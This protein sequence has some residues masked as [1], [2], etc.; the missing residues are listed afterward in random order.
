MLQ[1]RLGRLSRLA[2]FV[3]VLLSAGA[4]QASYY[5][6]IPS[7]TTPLEVVTYDARY[8]YWTQ[9][10]YI[11]TYPHHA[12]SREGWTSEYYG[13]VQLNSAAKSTFLLWSTW[14]V[15][16]KGAPAS[17]IDFVHAGPRLGWHRSTWE[18]S[19]GGVSGSWPPDEFKTGQ[20]YRFVHRVWR[21]TDGT[22]HLGYAGVWMKA[23]ET[24]RWYHMATFKF[25][26]ELTGFNNMFGF[27][28]WFGPD[29]PRKAAAEFRN[30][31]SLT[32]GQWTSRTA[33]S[34]RN[35]GD[36]T[37][38]IAP[39][40]D[41]LGVLMETT[42]NDIDPAT[43]RRRTGP[44]E[45]K[46]LDIRQ[47]EQ[48]QILDQPKVGTPSARVLGRQVVCR[49]SV[50]DM[51]SPQLGYDLAIYDGQQRVAAVSVNDPEAR[52]AVVELPAVPTGPVSARLRLRDIFNQS[53]AEVPILAGPVP[54][55]AATPATG[56]VAGLD[57]AYY[58]APAG[59]SWTRLPA[60]D[61][62]KPV[63]RGVTATPDITPRL[64]RNGYA[65]SYDG[66]LTVPADGIYTF[67]L[68]AA[69]GARLALDG[70]T[71][72]DADGNRS[73]ARYDGT[74]A[75]AKGAHRLAL[76][77]Y[78][79]DGRRNQ[80][81]DFLQLSWA[82]P[83]FGVTP[84]PAAAFSHGAS[85]AATAVVV[86]PSQLDPVHLALT[87]RVTGA[88]TTVA[89]VEYWAVN[90]SFDYFAMQGAR[91]ACYFLGAGTQPEQPVTAA[92]WSG[93]KQV[94]A[95][96]VLADGRTVDSVPVTVDGMAPPEVDANGMKLTSLEHHLYPLSSA[97]TDGRVTLVG[98]SMGLLTRA[99][100]G[101]VTI[102]AHLA[103][104]TSDRPLADGTRPENS[105][106]WY[107]GLILRNNADARPGEPLGGAD[108]PY[109]ALFGSADGAT[110]RCD[111]TMIDGAGNQPSGDIGRDSKWFRLVRR[112][113]QLS[114]WLSSDGQAWRKVSSIEQPKLAEEIQVGF[115][116][117]A[118]PCATP[119][120]HWAT[121]D[122]LTILDHAVE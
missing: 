47:P 30:V 20:W 19:S 98:E 44:V 1:A 4:V 96:A 23:L 52:L 57:Y 8:P 38:T 97:A 21:P 111:S 5:D 27:M 110:R 45:R 49:W 120:V 60:V 24:G 7:S 69:S 73:I 89:K 82:G 104:M 64:R 122:H 76:A 65:L 103:G 92:A 83:G 102:T 70:R 34:A 41:G 12:W 37:I 10:I 74:T 106:N 121:F 105:G 66:L 86:T 29:A 72:V 109:I 94:F 58:E 14:Q 3:L 51:V 117:Y 101:D 99:H 87:S 115:V 35:S 112:G 36:N 77:F 90:A 17:G 43:K 84:V 55:T 11:A 108:I 79:G 53:T 16:G 2:G 68:T 18:G 91:S 59:E 48:P 15:R 54:P 88:E 50:S 6:L 78:H 25:P 46:T 85:P 116:Q 56:T 31:Y 39:G 93:A 119:V 95:R 32:D 22:P 33:F 100:R 26:A 81:D 113:Q 75:L 42:A 63:R 9:Q 61:Q 107:S 13:G 28:E 40:E 67:S 118:V 62:L 71:V 114:A 80:A